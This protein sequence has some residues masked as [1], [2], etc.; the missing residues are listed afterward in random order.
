M[1]LRVTGFEWDRGNRDKCRKHGVSL[2][3]IK[4]TF[5]GPI[6][7]FPDPEHSGGE[8]RLKAI[9]QTAEGRNV[10]MVFTLRDHG[11]E[12]FIRPISA[13]FM[14]RKEIGYYEKESAKTEKR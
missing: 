2:A 8:E 5:R 12:T 9:G 4:S 7:V 14:H 11:D 1:D 10:L 3:E 6:A 13:R